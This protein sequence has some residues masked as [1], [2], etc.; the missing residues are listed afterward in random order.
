MPVQTS[1]YCFSIWCR[2]CIWT[3]F[4]VAR[5]WWRCSSLRTSSGWGRQR[6]AMACDTSLSSLCIAVHNWR[7]ST[8]SLVISSFAQQNLKNLAVAS[9][10]AGLTQRRSQM[11]SRVCRS[12]SNSPK[13]VYWVMSFHKMGARGGL[14]AAAWMLYQVIAFWMASD[15]CW[16]PLLICWWSLYPVILHE[17]DYRSR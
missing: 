2:W 16:R 13:N 17:H 1:L 3:A 10:I 7:I 9:R 15:L 12:R 6:L 5:G 4:T 11:S 8:F 14:S